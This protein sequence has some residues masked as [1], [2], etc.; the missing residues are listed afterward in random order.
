MLD[1]GWEKGI[2]LIEGRKML[3]NFGEIV[4]LKYKAVRAEPV[5]V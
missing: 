1:S 2:R 3:V 5:E 4:K